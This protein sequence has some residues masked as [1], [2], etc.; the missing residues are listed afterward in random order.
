[1]C[2]SEAIRTGH[3]DG[4]GASK[5]AGRLSFATLHLF[6]R[7]GR[8][9]I[10]PIF[11]QCGTGTG[12]VGAQLLEALHW[13]CRVLAFEIAELCPWVPPTTKVCRI[14]VDAASTPACCA[15]VAFIDGRVVYTC[16]PPDPDLV[17][18]LVKRR[19]NQ[20]MSLVG[21][22]MCLGCSSVSRVCVQEI[23]GIML[24]LAT[25]VDSLHGRRVLLYSDNKGAQCVLA[26]PLALLLCSHLRLWS[27]AEGCANPARAP[28][29]VPGGRPSLPTTARSHS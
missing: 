21:E 22:R 3:L 4:V 29:G 28:G 19:D 15:A 18:R 10:K 5:L 2:I 11:A 16:A 26:V 20:I 6:R 24:A 1:M 9:M 23:M 12:H 7:L 27:G 14:F 25:F 17:C 13:W 8:A